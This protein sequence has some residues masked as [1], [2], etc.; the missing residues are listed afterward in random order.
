MSRYELQPTQTGLQFGGHRTGHGGHVGH[1][2]R[3]RERL[4]ERPQE[5]ERFARVEPGARDVV[6]AL[7]RLEGDERPRRVALERLPGPWLVLVPRG[8]RAARA[9]TSELGQLGTAQVQRRPRRAG[10]I[11]GAALRRPLRAGKGSGGEDQQPGQASG[12]RGRRAAGEDGC[13]DV[14]AHLS[15]GC[16]TAERTI[17]FGMRVSMRN[18]PPASG[19]SATPAAI[20]A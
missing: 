11:R 17:R 9:G 16:R 4:R 7:H 18:Q 13:T 20:V 5:G 3:R 19:A 8:R 12:E 2:D 10:G 15:P 6:V 1:A 14:L